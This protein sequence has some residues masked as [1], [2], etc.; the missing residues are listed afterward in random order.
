MFSIFVSLKAVFFFFNTHRLINITRLTLNHYAYIEL[1]YIRQTGPIPVSSRRN[2][3]AMKMS[4][5]IFIF[6]SRPTDMFYKEQLRS[7][8]TALVTVTERFL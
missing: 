4:S 1:L 3:T 7:L 2:F 6:L 8:R 5:V